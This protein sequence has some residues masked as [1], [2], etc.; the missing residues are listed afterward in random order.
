MLPAREGRHLA[1]AVTPSA[2]RVHFITAAAYQRLGQLV[3]AKAAVAKG[4]EQRPTATVQFLRMPY[5]NASPR[6]VAAAEEIL[7]LLAEAGVP[8]R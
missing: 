6:F 1:D 8:E 2:G 3:E 7:R 5:K 4:L